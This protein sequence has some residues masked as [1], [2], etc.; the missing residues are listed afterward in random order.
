MLKR[1]GQEP[2]DLPDEEPLRRECE[3]FIECI[4]TRQ[5]P[6]TDAESGVRVLRVLEACQESMRQNGQPISLDEY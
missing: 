3:H 6:L 5:T 2:V 1:E 4:Q